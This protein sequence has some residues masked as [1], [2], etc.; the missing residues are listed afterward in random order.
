MSPID[1]RWTEQ[2]T[3]SRL[4]TPALTDSGWDINQ[5]IREDF[6]LTAGRIVVRGNV[7][8]RERAKRADYVLELKPNIPLAVI[9]AKDAQQQVGAGMQQALVYAHMLD[10]PFVFSTN[11]HE[12]L[13]HDK[14][15][16]SGPVER[17]LAPKDFPTPGDLWERY[18]SWKQLDEPSASVVK[19]NF[20]VEDPRKTLRY[21]QA[22][23]VNRTVEAIASGQRR[24]LLVMATGTGKTL[25][26][27]QIIW[28]LRQ[29]GAAKRVLFLVDRNVLADQALVN[30]FR[31]F[32]S[33]M[34]KVTDRNVNKS[35]E[36][37]TALYQSITGTEEAQNIYKQF[38]R[39]FFDLIV[40]DECHR[41]SASEDSAWRAV[42]EYF[43]SS[44]Q[45]GLTATP[46]ETEKVSNIEYFG[47]PVYTYSL[48]NGIDDGFLA[49]F[50]VRRVELDKDIGGW[51]PTSG[52]RDRYGNLVPDRI[53]M[54]RDY[55]RTVILD[56][57]SV[58]VAESITAFMKSN[59]RYAKTIVFC[60][61]IDHA[62]RMRQ[63]LV[64][65]NSDITASNDKYVVRITGDSQ[66]GAVDLDAFMD[67]ESR[68]PV[69]VTT[70]KL[71][72]TGV[73]V[74]TCKVIALDQT[75]NSL[76][77]F[78]Q[79]IGR[80]TRV[81]EDY[82]KR[83]FTILDFRG[84]TR[85]F[86]DP[87]FDGEPEQTKDVDD[88]LNPTPD[89]EPDSR[90]SPSD[91][92]EPLE[93]RTKYFVDGVP[94][95]VLQERVQYFDKNGRLVTESLRDYT[96]GRVLGSF[97]SLDEFLKR[98]TAAEKKG[99][100]I[101]ELADHGVLL[102]AL[103]QEVGRGY[104]P[105]DLICHVV[106]DAPARTRSERARRVREGEYFAA[107]GA[108]ARK[109]L[110]GLLTQYAVEGPIG[111]EDANVLRIRPLS[112]IGTPVEI[113][114]AFGGRTAYEAAV[115]ALE[116]CIYESA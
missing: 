60:E 52:Q 107:Y 21:Y 43:S 91:D 69:I 6:P 57:R 49:P 16:S 46:K 45:I 90:Q 33:V 77:E 82:D 103:E 20:Y 64:N 26:A 96:R 37:Y 67:P 71:L 74:Q 9:E 84:A 63:E 4:I 42:L 79:I 53:Y 75:I 93:G 73:D 113:I 88:P 58:V 65:A 41:G 86:A 14:T 55:D 99:A 23:A 97:A 27:F 38:S 11:G 51:R 18:L 28:R 101:R 15:V 89:D 116:A 85:L 114:Q 25:T 13:F 24:V 80:G 35:Y 39:D 54:G 68:F 36:V 7:H 81:R 31:A 30:D 87:E 112:D 44:I 92:T 95:T 108:T 12:F 8:M 100:V 3:R 32:G 104:D 56:K 1:D 98:W 62:E 106:F 47:D 66:Y 105:F 2:E 111:I 5:Q 110:D 34:T 61:D 109:V 17:I 70:S 48:R 10:V 102:E 40:I 78:K 19:Q 59:D 115:Q 29:A 76:T 83:W 72:T 50:K 94:V 22:V